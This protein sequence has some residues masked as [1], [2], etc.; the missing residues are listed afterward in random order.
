M[1][2]EG[3]PTVCT[4]PPGQVRLVRFG[5]P[6]ALVGVGASPSSLQLPPPAGTEPE[7]PGWEQQRIQT[8]QP[9]SLTGTG[10]SPPGSA[11]GAGAPSGGARLTYP[12]SV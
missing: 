1:G 9:Q 3:T 12:S 10:H 8:E 6:A 5:D 11:P 4:G 7:P 2:T